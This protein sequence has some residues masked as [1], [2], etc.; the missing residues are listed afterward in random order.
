VL[1]DFIVTL[2]PCKVC[3]TGNIKEQKLKATFFGRIKGEWICEN[4]HKNKF[5]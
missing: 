5:E 1:P 2:P 4:G 3:G